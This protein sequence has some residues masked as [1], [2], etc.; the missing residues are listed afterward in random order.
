VRARARARDASV[1]V[2]AD[3]VLADRVLADRKKILGTG[4]ACFQDE[5]GPTERVL[6]YGESQKV[7]VSVK[8][9]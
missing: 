5:P 4:R 3:R 1:L 7:D 6:G 2:L 9:Y 8:A